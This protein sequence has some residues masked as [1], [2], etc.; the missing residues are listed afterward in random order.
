ME[1]IGFHLQNEIQEIDMEM[2][3]SNIWEDIPR[4]A[5]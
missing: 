1:I 3:N 5:S 4:I 2:H